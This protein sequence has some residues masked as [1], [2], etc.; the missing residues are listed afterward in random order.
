[1]GSLLDLEKVLPRTFLDELLGLFRY[2][3]GSGRALLAG[4]PSTSVLLYSV[5]LYDPFL[6]VTS[7]WF[8]S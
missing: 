5:C 4:T 7:S 3:S 8:R 2:P 6:A 1:M